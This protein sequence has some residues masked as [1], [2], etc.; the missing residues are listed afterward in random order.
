MREIPPG[1]IDHWTCQ[2]P[3]EP[4][5]AVAFDRIDFM[6]LA[7]GELHLFPIVLT[8]VLSFL[9]DLGLPP[10]TADEWKRFVEQAGA[11]DE[12]TYLDARDWLH[13]RF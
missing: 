8:A 6:V 10:C 4:V 11:R 13:S 7:R 3:G 5:G 1:D 2:A 9:E 12:E